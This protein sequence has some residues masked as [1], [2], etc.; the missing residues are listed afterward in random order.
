MFEWIV[1]IGFI[2]GFI[3]VVIAVSLYVRSYQLECEAKL[4]IEE[5]RSKLNGSNRFLFDEN[6]MRT[7]FP[8]YSHF[9]VHKV[10]SRLVATKAIERDSMDGS[11]CIK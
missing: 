9:I 3:G 5:Y 10:W 11:W 2:L 4:L 6:L 7:V 1:I 8:E